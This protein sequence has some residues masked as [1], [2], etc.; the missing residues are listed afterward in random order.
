VDRADDGG[1]CVK[2][3]ESRALSAVVLLRRQQRFQLVADGLPACVLVFAGDGI[4]KDGKGDWPEASEAGKRL[5]FLGCC[6][7]LFVLDGL[8]R[9]DRGND[10]A[11]LAFLSAGDRA[12]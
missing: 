9:A 2:S 10:V 5:F 11:G 4:G 3:V 8:Q 7:P 6:R 12:I 1:R